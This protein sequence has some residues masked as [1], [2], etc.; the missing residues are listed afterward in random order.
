LQLKLIIFVILDEE[1]NITRRQVLLMPILT[2]AKITFGES[3]TLSKSR[4]P[5]NH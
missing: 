3:Y 1:N 4:D 2:K 5:G